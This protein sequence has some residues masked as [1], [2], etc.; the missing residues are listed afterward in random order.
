M[1]PATVAA[2]RIAVADPD[3]VARYWQ[4]VRLASEDAC[5]YWLGAVSGRGHGRFQLADA[6]SPYSLA[7]GQRR[8][9]TY[10]VIAHRFGY[11]LHAG[12]DALLAVPLLSHRCDNP[13][14]QNPRHWRPSNP[15]ANRREW[16][17][18][19]GEVRGPLAD[20]RGSRGRARAVRDAVRSGG[21]VADVELAGASEA[22]RDQLAL[23]A[24]QD[25]DYRP[26]DAAG[27]VTE[28]PHAAADERAEDH[29]GL[30]DAE[31]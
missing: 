29:P 7:H 11:A 15:T 9:H 21:D 10:V 14:C 27:P 24:E 30:F 28:Q 5:W 12:V 26:L 20:V 1:S 19:R 17:A 8:R 22:H 3:T 25:R 18:R 31:S 4:H 23:F 2:L 16:A 13:L 6:Y